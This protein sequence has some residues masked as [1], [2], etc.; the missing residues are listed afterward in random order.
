GR[1]SALYRRL[2]LSLKSSPDCLSV[3]LS[4]STSAPGR[5]KTSR[6][7]RA[8]AVRLLPLWRLHSH[9]ARE[10][11]EH[12]ALAC[13]GSGQKLAAV[14]VAVGSARS[15]RSS[16]VSSWPASSRRR[17]ASSFAIAVSVADM[18][19][20]PPHQR[21]QLVQLVPQRLDRVRVVADQEL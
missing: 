5:S 17:S 4:K 21:L 20:R 10:E 18:A 16:G 7:A 13:Q 6:R 11:R 1:P 8:A 3:G 14:S 19:T 2:A 9:R 12:R 15:R